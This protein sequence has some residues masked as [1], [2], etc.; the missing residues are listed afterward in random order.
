MKK[1]ISVTIFLLFLC[2][3]LNAQTADEIQT[4]LQTQIVS[5]SQAV[6]FVLEAT[7]VSDYYDKTN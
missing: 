6:R 5:Y 1:N 7:D 4:L 3:T 2:T